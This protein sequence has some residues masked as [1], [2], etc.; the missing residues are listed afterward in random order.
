[1]AKTFNISFPQ[2]LLREVDRVAKRE[3]RSRSEVIRGATR[4]YLDWIR[5]WEELQKESRARAKRLGIRPRD[6]ERLVHEVRGL[7]R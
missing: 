3:A 2:E 6:V 7:T 4:T 5:D 1:M